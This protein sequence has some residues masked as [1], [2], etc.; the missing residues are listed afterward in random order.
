MVNK[1]LAGLFP[2]YCSLCGL[3]SQRDIPLCLPCQGV[4]AANLRCCGC[5]A[6]PLPGAAVA[7]EVRYCPHCLSHTPPYTRVVAPWLYDEHIAF[8][9]QRW[10]FHGERRLTRLF[11]Q[12]WL[13]G[14]ALP[15]P[16]DVIVPVPLHWRRLY[17]RGFNQSELL[18]RSLRRHC[19][20]IV[21]TRFEPNFVSRSRATN[22]QSG[23]TA[24]DRQRNL[25]AAFTVCQ[26]CD[27]LR[28]AVVDD[29]VTTGS[30]VTALANSL[31]EAGAKSVEVWCIARTP[32]P[33]D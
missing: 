27:D 6:L 33:P 2:T 11:A 5:C 9:L 12:L 22:S 13:D 15:S 23:L 25:C 10:K 28:I 32:A 14:G 7:G 24:K 31:R 29:V 19:P 18:G 8:L 3:S 1:I 20:P 4:L 26:P 21:N 16:V 17:Q 30:T